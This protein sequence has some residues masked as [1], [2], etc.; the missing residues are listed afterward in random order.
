[1][2]EI[3]IFNLTH[4]SNLET[5]LKWLDQV[6]RILNPAPYIIM[7]LFE[8]FFSKSDASVPEETQ[9][10]AAIKLI[11]AGKEN[12]VK[13]M[14][15]RV[16]HEVGVKLRGDYSLAGQGVG[17]GFEVLDNGDMEIEVEYE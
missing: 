3:Q 9:V 7:E 6:N 14:K 17:L 16:S 10:D 4:K 12:A 1:M 11:K 13:R 15:I 8:K 2:S 5:A